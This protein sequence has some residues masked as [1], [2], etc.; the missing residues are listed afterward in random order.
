[1]TAESSWERG[2]PPILAEHRSTLQAV[3]QDAAYR[4]IAPAAEDRHILDVGSGAGFGS[5]ALRAA[6][7]RSV[8][9][10]D[11]DERA[12]EIATRLHGEDIRFAAAEL[13]A[14]GLADSSFDLVV[15]FEEAET[16]RRPEDAIRAL[17]RLVAEGGLLA[18]SLP[19]VPQLDPIS[20]APVGPGLGQDQWEQLLKSHF[21]QVRFCRRRSSFGAAVLPIAAEGAGETE[22]VT[23]ASVGWVGADRGEEW[24]VLAVAGDELP[25]LPPLA[26]L[27]GCRDLRAYR[28]TIA[29]WEQRARRAEA[30]GAA[31]HWELVASR[32]AQRRLRKRLWD[33]EHTPVRRLFRMLRGQPSRLSEGPPIRPPELEPEAWD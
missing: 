22:D 14:N 3:E 12:V 26:S 15:C 32:E 28:D 33:L 9:G 24:S 8:I 11:P 6:G 25:D 5:A 7:A 18:V 30:E 1:M 4:W 23:F 13:L 21:R 31:K 19:I 20:G 27:T 2:D 10:I 17:S 29:A 16:G